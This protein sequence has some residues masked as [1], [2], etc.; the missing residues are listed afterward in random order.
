[1]PA[2]LAASGALLRQTPRDFAASWTFALE[3]L[4]EGR[5]RLVER[6]RVRFG[7]ADP[8]FRF[9]GPV[10]G[11]GVVVMMRRQLLGLA[12]RA[13]RTAVAPPVGTSLE[14]AAPVA[15]ASRAAE[16]ATETAI[17]TRPASRRELVA[18]TG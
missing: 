16:R 12:E 9:V 11:F 13:I 18:T 15:A 8:A 4:P 10:L 14:P 5:T 3:P 7:H 2:G 17:A 6:F 1:M